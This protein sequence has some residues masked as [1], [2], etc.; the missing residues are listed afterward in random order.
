MTS[1]RPNSPAAMIEPTVVFLNFWIGASSAR[2]SSGWST[3]FRV[4]PHFANPVAADIVGSVTNV[5]SDLQ[6][7]PSLLDGDDAGFDATFAAARRI[8][9]DD[10]A[11]I[12]HAAGWVRGAGALFS[13]ILDTAPW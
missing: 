3:V 13:A 6:W 10:T 11:W 7:Q 12:E 9:L 1:R 4:P 5:R 8:D 2:S